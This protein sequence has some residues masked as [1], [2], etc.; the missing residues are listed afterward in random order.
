MPLTEE[1]EIE[2]L[3]LE[4]AIEEEEQ[5]PASEFT[6]EGA[7]FLGTTREESSELTKDIGK[8][9]LGAA[10]AAVAPIVVGGARAGIAIGALKTKKARDLYNKLPEAAKL[11]I[12]EGLIE[13]ISGIAGVGALPRVLRMLM[14]RGI[15]PGKILKNKD[16]VKKALDMAK[17]T[18]K[19]GHKV[20]KG[21]KI[22]RLAKEKK[23]YNE[24]DKAR[25]RTEE[26]IE[27]IK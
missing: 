21:G 25:I 17:K 3:E 23:A 13:K 26:L 1:E 9:A 7:G 19:A 22:D 14:R 10:G 18:K 4:I 12:E 27:R 5:G 11:V 15:K 16:T 8:A 6:P 2:L 20:K 24:A